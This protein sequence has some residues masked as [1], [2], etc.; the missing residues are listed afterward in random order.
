MLKTMQYTWIDARWNVET[1]AIKLNIAPLNP[2]LEVNKIFFP[3]FLGLCRKM[4]GKSRKNYWQKSKCMRRGDE[5]WRNSGSKIPLELQEMSKS[6]SGPYR[7]WRP[8]KAAGQ[9]RT[10]EVMRQAKKVYSADK[11]SGRMVMKK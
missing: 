5:A 8:E 7:R 11:V 1:E 3:G 2:F 6:H 9:T 4:G 10:H